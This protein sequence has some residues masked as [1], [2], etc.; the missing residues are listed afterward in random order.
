MGDRYQP[1]QF[2]NDQLDAYFDAGTRRGNP[3]PSG[4][5]VSIEVRPDFYLEFTEFVGDRTNNQ[6]EWLGLI[7][8]LEIAIERFPDL[9]MLAIRSD[10]KLIVN[11]ALGEWK[12]RGHL[13][14]LAIR[15]KELA[16]QLVKRGCK[17]TIEHVP[18]EQNAR[19]DRLVTRLL[20]E[21]LGRRRGY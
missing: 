14:S 9:R 20:D 17:V 7:K 4:I 21:H 11:Q 12:I 18:R 5:A 6:A 13:K 10:S 16:E 3:G 2:A 1:H 19:A 15:A 8:A